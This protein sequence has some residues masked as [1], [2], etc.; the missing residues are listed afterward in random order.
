MD[1]TDRDQSGDERVIAAWRS[2]HNPAGLL[3]GALV[4]ASVIAVSS[5]VVESAVA[6]TLAV[7]EV[8]LV[9]WA[10]HVYS[11]VLA[12]RL[13]DPSATAGERTREAVRHEVSVLGGGVPALLVF[14]AASVRGA[15][16]GAAANLALVATIVLLGSAG[17]AVGRQA[18]AR[19][20]SL[21][22]EVGIAA[23][24]GLLVFTLKAGGLH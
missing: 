21:V 2:Q 3:Y 10:A 1:A 14:V 5:A 23:L 16:V 13:A 6:L 4:A 19:G 24:L 18:G 22:R 17:Y 9:Y 12:D 7:V 11:R 15:S 8:L 20:W